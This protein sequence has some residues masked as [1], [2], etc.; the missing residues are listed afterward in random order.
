M[1]IKNAADNIYFALVS[2]PVFPFNYIIMMHNRRDKGFKLFIIEEFTGNLVE[3]QYTVTPDSASPQFV[4][5]EIDEFL[6]Q[7][8]VTG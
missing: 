7:F 6:S 3:Y 5:E 8:R 4:Y 1:V 2:L